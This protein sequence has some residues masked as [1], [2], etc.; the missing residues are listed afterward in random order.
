MALAY[1]QES[2]VEATYWCSDL[3]VKRR[4]LM[5][6][7]ADFCGN[8]GRQGGCADPARQARVTVRPALP[9]Q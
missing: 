9:R 8:T 7:W 5:E 4:K 2:K 3:L 6:G 1:A